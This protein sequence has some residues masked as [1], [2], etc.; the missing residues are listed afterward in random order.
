MLT[1]QGGDNAATSLPPRVELPE[2]LQRLAN[3]LLILASLFLVVS[4]DQFEGMHSQGPENKHQVPLLDFCTPQSTRLLVGP[5]LEV[6]PQGWHR[7][8][9]LC[10]SLTPT[11]ICLASSRMLSF[12]SLL[13]QKCSFFT[14]TCLRKNMPSCH[15]W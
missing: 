11:R 13:R 14:S 4:R 12:L 15:M 9:A 1:L 7:G 10:A 6:W 3:S 8:H 5:M 2:L